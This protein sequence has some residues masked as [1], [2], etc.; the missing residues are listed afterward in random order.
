MCSSLHEM[1]VASSCNG[2]WSNVLRGIYHVLNQRE[3]RVL[4][5]KT[6]CYMFTKKSAYAV[7]VTHAQCK[8]YCLERLHRCRRQLAST[9][10]ELHRH[11]V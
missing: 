11:G 7:S 6:T 3:R 9:F 10:W 2:T 5:R 8:C 1:K 4:A